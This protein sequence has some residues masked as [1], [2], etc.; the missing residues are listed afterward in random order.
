[1]KLYLEEIS[2]EI[3]NEMSLKKSTYK[4]NGILYSEVTDKVIAFP[5]YIKG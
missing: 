4:N 3:F 5:F 1:M 2:K